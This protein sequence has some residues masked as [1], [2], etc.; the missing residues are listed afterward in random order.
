MLK[1][2]PE[3][4]TVKGVGSRV[5]MACSPRAASAIRQG[6]E[7]GNPALLG[8]L[9]SFGIERVEFHSDRQSFPTE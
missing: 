3:V 4:L 9:K 5:T 2:P 1:P 6:M 7:M 8:V